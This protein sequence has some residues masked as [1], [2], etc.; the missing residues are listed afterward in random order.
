MN[1]EIKSLPFSWN[2]NFSE[3]AIEDFQQI[4]KDLPYLTC[5]SI[6]MALAK[7]EL[8][9]KQ[10]CKVDEEIGVDVG[11]KDECAIAWTPLPKRNGE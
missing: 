7:L 4:Q 1:T 2:D 8:L 6:G 5:Q 9:E 11:D 10:G 3:V